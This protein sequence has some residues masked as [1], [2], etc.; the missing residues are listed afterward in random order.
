V[1]GGWFAGGS[2]SLA[3]GPFG[4]ATGS[5]TAAAN[6]PGV[7]RAG[8][9]RRL[10]AGLQ[11]SAAAL[12]GAGWAWRQI[13]QQGW[14]TSSRLPSQNGVKSKTRPF[15]PQAGF[16]LLRVPTLSASRLPPSCQSEATRTAGLYAKRQSGF[17]SSLGLLSPWAA[18][19]FGHGTQPGPLRVRG[20]LA[21]R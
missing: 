13:A 9:A 14:Q 17:H 7:R 12:P 1:A 3:Q 8:R 10:L 2:S 11:K 20:I 19:P 5:T 4:R 15:R 21:V 18:Q 16:A 6:V